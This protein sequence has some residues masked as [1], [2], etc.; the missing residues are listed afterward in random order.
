M[1]G[2]AGRPCRRGLAVAASVGLPV[3][4]AQRLG[5]QVAVGTRLTAY[6]PVNL[7]YVLSDL[8][9][10]YTK[11]KARKTAGLREVRLVGWPG[12]IL[13][14][15]NPSDARYARAILTQ[16]RLRLD[17]KK[18][19]PDSWRALVAAK[20]L[21]LGTGMRSRQELRTSESASPKPELSAP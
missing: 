13:D 19:E 18:G 8:E 14:P 2:A 16:A 6:K 10:T 1:D 11:R 21:W 20:A 9:C 12:N 4:Q 3:P 5:K 17:S 15:R 7:V